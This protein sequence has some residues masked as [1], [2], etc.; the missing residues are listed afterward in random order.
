MT[1]TKQIETDKAA[2]IA[3]IVELADATLAFK[4]ATKPMFCSAGS[5][6]EVVAKIAAQEDGIRKNKAALDEA[7]ARFDSAEMRYLTTLEAAAKTV[8]CCHD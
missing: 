7:Q 5:P 4:V 8:G 2:L 6:A 3:A 1:I